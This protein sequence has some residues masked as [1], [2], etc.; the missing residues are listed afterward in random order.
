MNDGAQSTPRLTGSLLPVIGLGVLLLLAGLVGPA[1]VNAHHTC[2]GCVGWDGLGLGTASLTYHFNTLTQDTGLTDTLVRAAVLSALDAWAQVVAITFTET[3]YA[4]L[5]RSLDI[6]WS[7]D[8]Y[9]PWTAPFPSGALALSY[10]PTP[11]NMEP[12][13]G[14]I[15]FNDA[16][17]WSLDGSGFDIFSVALH[18]IG[19]TL[20]LA[21]SDDPTAV[22]YSGYRQV[23]ALASDDIAGI[24]TLYAP[25][26][27]EA[28]SPT[29]SGTGGST[30]VVPEP[31]TLLL[32]GCALFGL[33]AWRNR[34]RFIDL[35]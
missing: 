1:E 19:H 11:N 31:G 18:E 27:T 15:Y 4:S 22:M 8:T 3:P 26:T 25:G 12:L 30:Q 23:T 13:A 21:H 17:T 20:G 24:R 35:I 29:G 7:S 32:L 34:A 9:G 5:T 28:A 6:G 2:M 16:Y 33:A 10:Y 14:N